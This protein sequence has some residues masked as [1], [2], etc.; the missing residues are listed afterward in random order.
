M[1]H[2]GEGGVKKLLK[3]SRDKWTP[4]TK[5]GKKPFAPAGIFIIPPQIAAAT[6]FHV[7]PCFQTGF[8]F[9]AAHPPR[10]WHELRGEP[11]PVAPLGRHFRPAAGPGDL[12]LDD[13]QRGGRLQRRLAADPRHGAGERLRGVRGASGR[14]RDRLRPQRDRVVQRDGDSVREPHVGDRGD[15]GHGHCA[16][17][18]HS[19]DGDR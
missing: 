3:T 11:P 18:D 5:K 1:Y 7:H 10:L 15:G 19:G 16:G 14:E 2:Q 12:D 4:P 13:G 17:A 6:L 8:T 9:T